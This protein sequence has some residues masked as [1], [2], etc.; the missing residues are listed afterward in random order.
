MKDP[1][2]DSNPDRNYEKRKTGEI[3]I[4]VEMLRIRNNGM[5]GQRPGLGLGTVLYQFIVIRA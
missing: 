2:S 3:R 5:Q 4:R 1:G